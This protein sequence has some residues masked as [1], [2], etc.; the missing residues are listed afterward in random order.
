MTATLLTIIGLL[1]V[2]IGWQQHQHELW[3][4]RLTQPPLLPRLRPLPPPS[5]LP[6]PLTQSELLGPS[7]ARQEPF[8][9]ERRV[10]AGWGT[11]MDLAPTTTF[12]RTP[13]FESYGVDVSVCPTIGID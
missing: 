1:L 12:R 2:F 8:L 6:H 9:L 11:L 4:E 5:P 13:P 7:A 3:A 10:N